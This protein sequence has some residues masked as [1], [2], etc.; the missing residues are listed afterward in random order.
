MFCKIQTL[1]KSKEKKQQEKNPSDEFNNEKEFQFE[2][3]I[4][5]E[6]DFMKF[7]ITNLKTIY[8][9]PKIIKDEAA[10]FIIQKLNEQSNPW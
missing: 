6:L 10:N 1:I 8:Y 5:E 4:K 9:I 3:Q 2:I 7:Q